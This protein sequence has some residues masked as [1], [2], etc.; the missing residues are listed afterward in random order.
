MTTLQAIWLAIGLG[1]LALIMIAWLKGAFGLAAAMAR[2]FAHEFGE[3]WTLASSG[4]PFVA[5][6]VVFATAAFGLAHP[7]SRWARWF[8]GDDRLA[9]ARERYAEDGVEIRSPG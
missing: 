9:E 7:L 4:E 3:S 6:V 1:L 8:Y 5:I 2:K